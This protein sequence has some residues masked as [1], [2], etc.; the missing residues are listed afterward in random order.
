MMKRLLTAVAARPNLDDA[1]LRK[2]IGQR[3]KRL[4]QDQKLTQRE[5]ACAATIAPNTLGG[6]EAGTLRTR[7]DK[8]V[9]V[10]RKL[11]TT[12]DALARP[13]DLYLSNKHIDT[14]VDPALLAGLSNEDLQI[15]QQYHHS[16]S[17][18]RTHV[19]H[20][21]SRGDVTGALKGEAIN[22]AR[23]YEKLLAETK[24]TAQHL[25]NHLEDIDAREKERAR[26]TQR[27]EG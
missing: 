9:R 24:T 10:A 18:V 14:H 20:S 1:A 23:R 5:L 7:W 2:L 4:R 15:A 16:T 26:S 17:A 12:P 22:F 27:R 3:I 8:L 25:M 19:R 6:L 13:D 11:N 21:L